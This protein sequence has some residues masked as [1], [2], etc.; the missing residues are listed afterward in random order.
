MQITKTVD[1]LLD[2]LIEISDSDDF[3]RSVVGAAGNDDN[4]KRII[5]YIKAKKEKGI[6]PDT[7]RLLTIAVYLRKGT[8]AE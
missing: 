7:S 6:V 4:R 3:V 2:L 5:N 8:A 1:E